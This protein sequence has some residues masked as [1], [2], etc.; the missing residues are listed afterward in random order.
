MKEAKF[1]D[2]CFHTLRHT[3]ASHLAMSNV[4][5]LIIGAILGHKSLAMVKRYSHLSTS[6]TATALNK[7]SSNLLEGLDD[8]KRETGT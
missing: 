7:V 3:S 2:V 4:N 5:E 1:K 8:Q 6:S